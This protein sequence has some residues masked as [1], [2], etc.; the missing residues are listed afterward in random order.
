MGVPKKAGD[1]GGGV[2]RKETW[3]PTGPNLPAKKGTLFALA[4][5]QMGAMEGCRQRQDVV[6]GGFEKDCSVENI[7]G[8]GWP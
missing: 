1:G 4:R 3:K 2:Q 6:K 5:G 7:W 8:L